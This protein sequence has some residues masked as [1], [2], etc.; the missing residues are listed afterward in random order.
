VQSLPPERQTTIEQVSA[1]IFDCDGTLIDSAPLYAKAW[2]ASFN[3]IG[4]AFEECWYRAR[5]GLSEDILIER[6]E[7]DFKTSCDKDVLVRGMRDKYLAELPSLQEITI[8][9][10]VARAAKGKMPAAV[11]SG[12]PRAIVA[13]S[14]LQ[15][16]LQT[17]FDTVVT[18]EDVRRPKPY[19]DLFLEAAQR[20]GVPPEKCLV[21]E[22]SRIGTQ[23]AQTAGMKSI[24]VDDI[25]AVEAILR[26][27]IPT[28]NS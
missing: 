22:D 18:I 27:I 23:A 24:L 13:P 28:M 11:A 12:G 25:A 20:L 5:N 2:G 7:A 17:L 4:H 3:E 16:G 21:F 9:A 10:N 6:F 19:P 14:L 26:Q 1:L 15:L 8:I